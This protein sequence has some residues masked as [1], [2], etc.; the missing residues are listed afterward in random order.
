MLKKFLSTLILFS[1]ALCAS[2]SAANLNPANDENFVF[3]YQHQG[4]ENY[5]LKDSLRVGEKNSLKTVD[6]DFIIFDSIEP[7]ST[8]WEKN[9]MA[10][11]YDESARKVYFLGA[12]GE[13]IFLNP[14]GTVAEG[15][16][17]AMG[18]ELIYNLAFGKKFYVCPQYLDAEKNYILFADLGIQGAGLYVDKKSLNVIQEDAG[19]C[20]ISIDEVQVPDANFGKTEIA[21]RYTHYYSYN[22][23]KNVVMRFVGEGNG[24]RWIKINPNITNPEDENFTNDARIAN[25]AYYL[26]TGKNFF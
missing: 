16:G 3:F 10:L 15:S 25:I 14:N 26:A 4:L 21:N 18:A 9:H 7:A 22:T 20:I 2:T 17:Y 12:T 11:A 23:K 19:G 6:F 8:R 24:D 13:L 5:L 1:V